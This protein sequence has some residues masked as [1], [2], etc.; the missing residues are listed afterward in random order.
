MSGTDREIAELIVDHLVAI[1]GGTCT[2]TDEMIEAEQDENLATVLAGLMILH[3]SLRH[4]QLKM[5][6]AVEELRR[7]K[8]A[9]ES[10]ASAKSDFLASVSHEVRTP[11]HVIIGMTEVM[12]R[13]E[14]DA[15]K[16]EDMETVRDAG[17]EL[18]AI[19]SDILD[20][21]RIE[22]GK[23]E[24]E[25][26]PLDLVD[27]VERVAEQPAVEAGRR[28][29]DLVVR[30]A[31]RT[32]RRLVGDAV[33]IRQVL[34]NL[35][36]N[37]VKFTHDGYI[38][39]SADCVRCTADEAELIVTVQDTGIGIPEG[40]RGKVFEKFAQADSST[41]RMYGGS[42]LGL[43]IARRFTELMGGSIG[44]R[45]EPGVGSTFWISLNLPLDTGHGAHDEE[46]PDLPPMRVLLVDD[47]EVSRAVLAE[48]LRS[49]GV[50]SWWCESGGE[51]LQSLA[52]AHQAGDPFHVALVDHDL[53]G[54]DGPQLARR[55]RQ[56][57][58][59]AA[60]GLVL[61]SSA[62]RRWD[63]KQVL[64]AGF[65]VQITRPVRRARLVQALEEL[66]PR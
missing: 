59:T 40:M 62:A 41:S 37:A 6:A 18:L 31:P 63:E 61:I 64:E 12:L 19:L 48:S 58:A 55:I 26:A 43:A 16:R 14:E 1:H 5:H 46:G 21:S 36:D 33:R 39:V 57:E 22:S 7:A 29:L 51:A 47:A 45:S 30:I 17:Q 54:M 25:S 2:I 3:E 13:R 32:P 27:I 24:V 56:D 50:E 38:L 23:I 4:R 15:G 34:T 28:G 44:V 42:G 66:K 53:R 60:T 20:L 35:V 10:A 11:L 9:A 49:W 52:E 65:D 8:E